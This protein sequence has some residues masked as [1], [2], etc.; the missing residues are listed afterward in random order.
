MLPVACA[1]CGPITNRK[2][3][4]MRTC[5]LL[6]ALFFCASATADVLVFR[7]GDRIS[8]RVMHK[9][10]TALVFETPHAG[11][12]NVNW[13]DIRTLATDKPVV[14][15]IRDD[16]A[17]STEILDTG[18]EGQ[19]VLRNSQRSIPL[20]DITF[21]NPT[22]EQ[23]GVGIVYNGRANLA[24]TDTQGNTTNRRL[25]AETAF[26]ARTRDY[27]YNIGAKINQQEDFGKQTASSWQIDGN[28]DWFLDKR[29]FRYV[30]SSFEHDRFKD[31]DLRSTVGG[32]YGLQLA[33][34]PRTNISIRGGLDYV[35][36]EHTT[37]ANENYPALGWGLR[38]SHRLDMRNIELFHEQDGFMQIANGSDVTLR[39]RTGVRV[40]IVSRLN[41]SIQLNL[42]WEKEPAP[43]R[44]S[45]DSVLLIGLGYE[46]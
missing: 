38:A 5:V 12:I 18:P 16:D 2:G 14:L 6:M 33:E 19:V 11:T 29:T 21:I 40:P 39:S 36:V 3:T 35:A 8:G 28:Y 1:R 30:R 34:N 4:P 26:A 13:A 20:Q 31:I 10:N 7:N 37:T 44:K 23:S 15:M 24:A 25:Y 46:W 9:H 32:G 43:G 45:T 17:L 41:A 27:R 42:D 22:P